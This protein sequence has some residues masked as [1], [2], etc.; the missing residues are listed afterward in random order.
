MKLFLS[1]K[2]NTNTH[3][4]QEKLQKIA[5][6]HLDDIIDAICDDVGVCRKKYDSEKILV[7]KILEKPEAR[8][9]GCWRKFAV[10]DSNYKLI[11]KLGIEVNTRY[12]W[13]A[14]LQECI[15]NV[16]SN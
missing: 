11:K 2:E 7:L 4:D 10:Y 16:K 12:E 8:L 15:L 3:T 6:A 5:Q 14:E 9:A 1:K 13:F